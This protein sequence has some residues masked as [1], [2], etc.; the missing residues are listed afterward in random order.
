MDSL[1]FKDF[2]VRFSRSVHARFKSRTGLSFFSGLISTTSLVVF[3]TARIDS[4]FVSSTA[5]HTYD[6]HMFTAIIHHFEGL[7]GFH[8]WLVS[9]VGRALHR[10]H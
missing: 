7:F 10:F 2:H 8:S 1:N 3:I 6:F 9:S 5:V 4:I